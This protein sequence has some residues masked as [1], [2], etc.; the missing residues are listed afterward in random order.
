[1]T[2][3]EICTRI[4]VAYE[5]LGKVHTALCIA[6][7]YKHDN[8][9]V[10]DVQDILNDILRLEVRLGIIKREDDTNDNRNL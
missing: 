5:Q 8:E 1:M 9:L 4:K 2:K 10:Y 3:Q 7:P 6:D